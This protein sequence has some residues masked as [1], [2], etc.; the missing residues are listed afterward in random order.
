MDI[1]TAHGTINKAQKTIP[2]LYTLLYHCAG[3]EEDSSKHG[4]VAC[5]EVCQV[6]T[7]PV[8]QLY[9]RLRSLT[10]SI[11]FSI[12]VSG[13]TAGLDTTVR[14]RSIE[15]PRTTVWILPSGKPY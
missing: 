11:Y 13:H 15:D 10:I 12:F 8:F 14:Y 6:I 2:T 7:A 1:Y 5:R 4:M 9:L 3:I